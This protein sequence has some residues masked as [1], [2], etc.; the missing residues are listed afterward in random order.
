[1]IKSIVYEH[2][3]PFLI[4]EKMNVFIYVFIYVFDVFS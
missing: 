3:R 2:K 1:M 4:K